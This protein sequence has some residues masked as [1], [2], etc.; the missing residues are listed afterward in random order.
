M[1][2]ESVVQE[3]WGEHH[4]VPVEPELNTILGVEFI[5]VSWFGES[6]SCEDHNSCEAVDK[7]SRV[8]KWSVWS[9]QKSSTNRSHATIDLEHPHPE[10]VDNSEGSMKGVS[11]VFSL[12]HLEGLEEITNWAWSLS[13]SLVDDVLKC[14]VGGRA[15][16]PR[17]ELVRHLKNYNPTH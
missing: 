8:I 6:K 2:R 12:A 5:L 3:W 17:L 11:R 10:V 7:K 9:T 14:F 4:V 15:E 16:E 1:C 13:E